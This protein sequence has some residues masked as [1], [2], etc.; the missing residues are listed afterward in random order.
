MRHLVTVALRRATAPSAPSRR[1][2]PASALT[3]RGT[4][5]GRVYTFTAL[6]G[7]V[8][9]AG[10][11]DTD[12]HFA[13]DA[14]VCRERRLLSCA[15]VLYASRARPSTAAV[16]WLTGVTAA[17]PGCRLAAAPLAEGGWSVLDS[18]S[19]RAVFVGLRV[20]GD[21][22]LLASCLHTWLVAGHEV[23]VLQNIHVVHGT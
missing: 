11:S 10:A 13:V 7:F 1:E 19:R 14:D 18:A 22:P 8:R 9:T 5:A 23:A 12:E 20:P 21:R 16:C 17:F 4:S 6:A 2:D 3:L 15:D